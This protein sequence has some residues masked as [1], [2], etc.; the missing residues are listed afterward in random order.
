MLE[1]ILGQMVTETHAPW[2]EGF[3][4]TP[5]YGQGTARKRLLFALFTHVMGFSQRCATKANYREELVAEAEL[6]FITS[7]FKLGLIQSHY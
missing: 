2:A 7:T 6:A 4:Q 3:A 5:H 1:G